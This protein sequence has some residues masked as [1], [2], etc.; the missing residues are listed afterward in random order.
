MPAGSDATRKTRRPVW[1]F[2]PKSFPM[3]IL[4]G[5]SLAVLPLIF[6]LVNNAISVH[7]LSTKSQRAVSNAVQATQNSR[8]LIEQLTG[9]ERSARQYSIL[10][11]PTLFQGYQAGHE[12]FIATVKRMRSLS[13]PREQAKALN[14]LAQTE[15][16]IFGKLTSMRSDP[17]HLGA[18]VDHYQVL[19]SLARSLD[20]TGAAIVAR[21]VGSM[22]GLS[23]EVQDFIYWQIVALVPVALFLVV[24]ATFLILKP[25]RQIE[26]ALR[27]LGDGD[28][29]HTV[30]V[31]GP[32]DLEALGRQL[33]WVRL[34]LAELEEQKTRFMRQVSHELKTPL[35]AVREG[36]ELLG[37][38]SVGPLSGDQLEVC[39]ILRQN[40]L[41][42]QRLIEDLLNY[43]TVQFQKSGL[44]VKRMEL[45]AI[46]SRVAEAHRLPVRAKEI[47]LKI[48]CPRIWL[49]ADENKL[50]VILDNLFSN[51]VKFSPPFGV[52]A[53][54][55]QISGG[56]VL[57]DV[58][59]EG[60]G[61]AVGE[62]DKVFDPFYQ[63]S[64]KP[65]GPV[66]G[67][68]LGLAI[69]REYVMAHRG[70][71]QVI[72]DR[73]AGAHMRVSLP[74]SHAKGG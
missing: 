7:E 3:L 68:G 66:K 56:H 36:A 16:I 60:P 21:E 70:R 48:E 27:R 38:G 47:K 37:D 39:R 51:A 59:D 17:K 31:S 57:I 53:A 22:Q 15:N 74:I 13:L 43:H 49:E 32:R 67:T 45:A 34:R 35:S 25:I 63:G 11:E 19:G 30:S 42:L 62:R 50:E 4:A 18:V 72:Q 71:V 23:K 28:F 26:A 20:N 54:T 1:R 65:Q 69:V 5:F 52:V 9:M 44:N 8:L 41:K 73:T 46:L 64:A 14:E 61:I 6:A 33:D 12:D 29:T 10:G 55:A 40:A 24:G 58:I 2:Y